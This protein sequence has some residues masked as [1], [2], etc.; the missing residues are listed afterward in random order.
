MSTMCIEETGNKDHHVYH[1]K[2][3]NQRLTCVPEEKENQE[4]HVY[5]KNRKTKTIMCTRRTGNPRPSYVPGESGEL[6]LTCVS[7]ETGEL[8]WGNRRTKTIM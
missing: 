1:W 3:E 2:Q 5:Q 4:H 6:G 8:S 7:R